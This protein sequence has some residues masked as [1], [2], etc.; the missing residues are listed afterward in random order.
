M[1][2]SSCPISPLQYLA[3]H[4]TLPAR[5]PMTTLELTQHPELAALV[6]ELRKGQPVLI[7]DHGATVGEVTLACSPERSTW[8]SSLATFRASLGL[9]PG[10]NAVLAMRTEDDR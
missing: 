10:E 9:T 1:R 7:T 8:L 4:G 6:D 2:A 3:R 5:C